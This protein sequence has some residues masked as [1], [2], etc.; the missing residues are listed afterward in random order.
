M[1]EL[2]QQDLDGYRERMEARQTRRLQE[3][4][5]RAL[6]R[7]Y[8]NITLGPIMVGTLRVWCVT[9]FDGELVAFGTTAAE[10]IANAS[11]S[12]P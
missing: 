9:A 5:L 1:L 7:Y 10:A 6:H 11:R 12:W 3:V 8:G 4:R 2:Q